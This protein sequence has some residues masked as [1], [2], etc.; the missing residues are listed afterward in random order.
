MIDAS[1]SLVVQE[2][3][4]VSVFKD[5][6]FVSSCCISSGS[7]FAKQ[8]KDPALLLPLNWKFNRESK[9]I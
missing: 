3:P 4:R 8:F 9:V 2:L 5:R 6:Y 1:D 7:G